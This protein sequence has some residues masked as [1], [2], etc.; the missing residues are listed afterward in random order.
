VLLDR[1][2]RV[3][4][5]DTPLLLAFDQDA[6]VARLDGGKRDLR[7][8]GELLRVTRENVIELVHGPGAAMDAVHRRGI[9]NQAGALTFADLAAKVADHHAHHLALIAQALARG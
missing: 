6:W 3:L 8:A 7:L 1:L 5:E 9:H 4:A 2:R